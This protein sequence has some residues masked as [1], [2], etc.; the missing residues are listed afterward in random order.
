MADILVYS[1]KQDTALELASKAKELAAVQGGQV[2][3]AAFGPGARERASALGEH[4]AATVYI[5]EDAALEGLATD[6]VAEA[7]TQLAKQSGAETIL[8]GSTRRGKELAGRLAQK[9]EAGAVTDVNSLVLEDGRLVASRYNLG[10]ATV[11]REAIE[12]PVKIF[13]VMPKTFEAAPAAGGP[14]QVVDAALTLS[15]S[16]VKLVD[17]RPKETTGV[18]L[19]AALRII[20]IGRGF[21]KQDDLALAQDLAAALQA[22]VGCTKGIS[23]VQWMAEDCVIGLSGLKTKPDF[24]L[25]VGISGQVQHTVGISSAK[26][27]AAINSDKDAPIFGMADYGIVGSLYDVLPALV[28]RLKSI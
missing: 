27:I 24:Y 14:A 13:A 21:G 8:L 28:Q 26:L 6:T 25:A 16:K 15:P 12:S 2:L 1:E 22:E 3:G 10:G 5:S 11:A 18:D 19:T 9:L 23:D 17:K 4:G 20:G 7:L